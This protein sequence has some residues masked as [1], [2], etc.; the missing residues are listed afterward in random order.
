MAQSY[1][2]TVTSSGTTPSGIGYR[3]V[4]PSQY[5]SYRTGDTG[6]HTQNGTFDYSGDPT[7]VLYIQ[8]LDYSYGAD[9]WYY[10]LHNNAFGSTNRFTTDIGTPASD[11]KASFTV[12]DF[13]G[14]TDAYVIDHLTG[15]GYYVLDLGVFVNS[16][17]NAIDAVITA[18]SVSTAGFNDWFPLSIEHGESVI[19]SEYSYIGVQNIFRY[20]D[21][22]G[23]PY[24][25][26]W[27]GCTVERSSTQAYYH[28]AAQSVIDYG[29]KT[30]LSSATMLMARNHY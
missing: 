13:T 28:R 18:N 23:V 12:A 25:F 24:N 14:A 15:V 22:V 9:S 17:N 5:T 20:I 7:C 11:G 19:N 8:D 26:F 3:R 16:W 4:I 1:Y 30:G 10:L 27:Y 21:V 29:V 6:W 2:V